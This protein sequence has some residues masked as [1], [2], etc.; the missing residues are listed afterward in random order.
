MT[1]ITNNKIVP[2]W[3]AT[4]QQKGPTMLNDDLKRKLEQI[5]V[6]EFDDESLRTFIKDRYG[7]DYIREDSAVVDGRVGYYAVAEHDD[8]WGNLYAGASGPSRD[9][10]TALAN[11]IF[12]LEKLR[13]ERLRRRATGC[14]SAFKKSMVTLLII[15]IV[16][17]ALMLVS[18]AIGI[19]PIELLEQIGHSG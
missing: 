18:A 10:S 11:L 12:A 6:R 3:I 5:G 15:A 1:E 19:S 14:W 2:A 17:G 8:L 7:V 4:N 16:V 9:E 13:G